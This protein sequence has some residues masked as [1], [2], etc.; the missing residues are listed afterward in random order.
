MR[1]N[2]FYERALVALFF[3]LAL[4][5]IA[6]KSTLGLP[7]IGEFAIFKPEHADWRDV[8]IGAGRP[9]FRMTTAI[10][11]QTIEGVYAWLAGFFF[12]D[13][14]SSTLFAGS[15][16]AINDIPRDKV[17]NLIIPI[18]AQVSLFLVL[19]YPLLLICRRAFTGFPERV[20]FLMAT[21]SVLI[22]WY[23]DAVNLW[24]KFASVFIDWPRSYYLFATK[25]FHYDFG[26]ICILLLG[27]LYLARSAHP[28]L[29]VI[30]VLA[31]LMQ[32][33]MEHLGI[34]FTLGVLFAG[35]FNTLNTTGRRNWRRPLLEGLTAISAAVGA[36]IILS[37]AFYALSGT[38]DATVGSPDNATGFLS[39]KWWSVVENNL[40]WIRT[41]TANVISMAILPAISGIAIGII[42]GWRN[43]TAERAKRNDDFRIA[44][45]ASGMI[46]GYMLT[47]VAGLFFVAY[48]AEMGRQFLALAVLTVI[49]VAKFTE[50][51][52]AR[53]RV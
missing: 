10:L 6:L 39:E 41:I 34:V 4:Y 24:F 28:S 23:P 43:R 7:Q 13:V 46:V 12:W 51:A 18:C 9:C 17:T 26:T 5:T 38:T 35:I 44:M 31:A 15:P 14:A 32:A 1:K 47:T 2:S 48:P 25:A 33:T 49:A 50:V 53:V 52:L 11:G 30:A 20:L 8:C 42:A 37:V 27:I 40:L 29:S 16:W 36:A 3:T 19:L 45:I 22:G 21:F